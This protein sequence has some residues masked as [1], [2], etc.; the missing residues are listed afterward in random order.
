MKKILFNYAVL[1][2]GLPMHPP[3][4]S[5]SCPHENTSRLKLPID[6]SAK[7]LGSG[8]GIMISK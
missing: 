5:L 8:W 7:T 4:S 2:G 6:F 1:S 3:V